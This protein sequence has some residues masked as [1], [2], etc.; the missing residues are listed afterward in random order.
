LFPQSW[1]EGCLEEEEPSSDESPP[2]EDISVPVTM[3]EVVFED[4]DWV[5]PTSSVGQEIGHFIPRFAL[6]VVDEEIVDGKLVLEVFLGTVRGDGP[7]PCNEVTTTFIEMDADH[8]FVMTPV[9]L[10]IVVEGSDDIA[11]TTVRGFSLEGTFDEEDA[12]FLANV[13][14]TMDLRETAKLVVEFEP[15]TPEVYCETVSLVAGTQKC[16]PC[17]SDGEPFCVE[18]KAL[19]VEGVELE[20]VEFE[21]QSRDEGCLE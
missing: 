18:M 11:M 19:N 8:R 13:E 7:D 14:A 6:Q 12:W 15:R 2:V 10:D 20:G 9:D 1:D 17:D 5:E 21:L 4:R 16:F 3:Y